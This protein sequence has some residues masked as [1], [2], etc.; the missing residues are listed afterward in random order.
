MKFNG[1]ITSHYA[2]LI[3]LDIQIIFSTSGSLPSH[4]NT[5]PQGTD[6]F[7]ICCGLP[8]SFQHGFYWFMLPLAV[9]ECAHFPISSTIRAD[10]RFHFGDGEVWGQHC[11]CA[12][13]LLLECFG[14][15]CTSILKIIFWSSPC[16]AAPKPVGDH[17]CDTSN[18]VHHCSGWSCGSSYHLQKS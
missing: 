13:K 6:I 8:I 4:G 5:R 16:W 7:A 15:F 12:V 17:R 3:K 18:T 1:C 2:E 10:T 14:L 9:S 11:P